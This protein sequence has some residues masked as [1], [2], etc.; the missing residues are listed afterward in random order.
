MILAEHSST[1]NIST[2]Y[3]EELTPLHLW[4][5]LTHSSQ[6]DRLCSSTVSDIIRFVMAHQSSNPKSTVVVGG[7][8]LGASITRVLKTGSPDEHIFWLLGTKSRTAS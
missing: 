7:G 5:E 2:V 1:C 4:K 8:L 6:S 3:S